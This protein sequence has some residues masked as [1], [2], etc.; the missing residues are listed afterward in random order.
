MRFA[1][2]CNP[3]EVSET[4][5]G[6]CVNILRRFGEKAVKLKQGGMAEWM[7]GGKGCADFQNG[8]LLENLILAFRRSCRA[9][10]LPTLGTYP[11]PQILPHRVHHARVSLYADSGDM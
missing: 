6:H 10:V 1:K 9:S 7:K 8:T 5:A 2:C 3:E 4:V 11:H